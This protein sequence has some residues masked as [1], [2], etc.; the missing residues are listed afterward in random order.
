MEGTV[1]CV[2]VN[3][4]HWLLKPMN[5]IKSWCSLMNLREGRIFVYSTNEHCTHD[6]RIH[7]YLQQ[8]TL[9]QVNLLNQSFLF[10]AVF[11][12]QKKYSQFSRAGTTHE[13]P[14]NRRRYNKTSENPTDN[15]LESCI[16]RWRVN[17][18]WRFWLTAGGFNE[19]SRKSERRYEK[20]TEP[21]A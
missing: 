10:W 1:Y 19:T 11:L 5:K 6:F 13:Q 21:C 17:Y 18:D 14:S 20:S 2:V 15:P 8:S 3:H 4:F 7:E 16:W 9:T 12:L